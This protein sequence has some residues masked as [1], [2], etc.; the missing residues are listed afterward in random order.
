M[1]D[2]Y[3]S[4]AGTHTTYTLVR[5]KQRGA[6]DIHGLSQWRPENDSMC[7]PPDPVEHL[8][9]F[10]EGRYQQF[11]NLLGRAGCGH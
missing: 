9:R 1:L 2:T 3:P 11:D 4:G 8:W 10:R 7:L 5:G 6:L